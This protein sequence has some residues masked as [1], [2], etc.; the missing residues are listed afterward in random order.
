MVENNKLENLLF[1]DFFNKA[2]HKA[3][4][5]WRDVVAE[6][7]RLGIPTPAFSCALSLSD[8]YH[9]EHLPAALQA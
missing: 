2:I 7:A 6:G 4:P 5:L 3:Q 1:N 8:R 9:S